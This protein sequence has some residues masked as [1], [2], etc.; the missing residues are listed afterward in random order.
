MDINA[1][2]NCT[3][4]NLRKAARAVTQ[5]YDKVLRPSGLRSTQ[6]SLL[7]VIA[8]LQPVG[9]KDLAKEL[10]M[11]RTTLGRN[12]KVLSDRGLL[13]IGEGDDRRYRPITL[14]KDGRSRSN[15]RS[16]F[17]NKPRPVWPMALART[18]GKNFLTIS[19]ESFARLKRQ[20]FFLTK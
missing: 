13:D 15:L 20:A 16:R 11:D 17:G 19:T 18:A 8:K 14:T 3:C 4:L 9:I 1:L 6:F 7:F 10:V 2:S 5:T 12:L